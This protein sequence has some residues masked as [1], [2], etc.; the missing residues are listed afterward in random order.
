VI[1]DS[2][3]YQCLGPRLLANT[4]LISDDES[5][6]GNSTKH[7]KNVTS[8]ISNSST[9]NFN[10]KSDSDEE[11]P[12]PEDLLAVFRAHPVKTELAMLS[13]SEGSSST[14]LR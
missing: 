4:S 14:S 10:T 13:L 2:N 6:H 5:I 7:K 8:F 12:E 9:I 11:L 3:R 1:E